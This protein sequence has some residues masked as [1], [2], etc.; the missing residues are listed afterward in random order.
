MAAVPPAVLPVIDRPQRTLD[1]PEK[2]IAVF[3]GDAQYPYHLRTLLVNVGEGRWFWATPTGA[4][5]LDNLTEIEFA[6]VGRGED[7][8]VSLTPCYCYRDG[9]GAEEV[10][11]WKQEALQR[12]EIMGLTPVSSGAAV[13]S[14]WYFSD[15]AEDMFGEE[16]P[17]STSNNNARF[18]VREAVAL[19]KH[20]VGGEEIWTTA[21]RVRAADR[22]EWLLD[23]HRG[24][25]RDYRLNEGRVDLP[26]ASSLLFREVH[27]TLK[28]PDSSQPAFF[29]GPS[30]VM[31]V[32]GAITSSGLE[33]Q[34]F[35]QNWVQQSGVGPRSSVSME[36]S[37]LMTILW[38]MGSVDLLNLPACQS[39]EFLCRRMLMIQTAVGRSPKQPDFDGL[40]IFIAHKM[41]PRGGVLASGFHKFVAEHQKSEA[42]IAKAQRMQREEVEADR[43]RRNNPKDKGK[44][45]DDEK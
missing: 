1:V 38:L 42:M 40:D 8:D 29:S 22:S 5:Q 12:C 44:K 4:V 7:V 41:D 26:G 19:A 31:E 13:D 14:K 11:R 21:E 3:Y 28:E 39:C 6:V 30:A 25:G 15:P 37:H 32:A 2:Q 43:K 24:A 17:L 36:H 34:A 9:V 10:S 16:V 27:R 45:G 35:H 18:V 33:P 23:K 20:T